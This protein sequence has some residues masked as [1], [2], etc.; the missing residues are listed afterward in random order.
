MLA[1]TSIVNHD[2]RVPISGALDVSNFVNSGASVNEIKIG[3]MLYF[4]HVDK[5]LPLRNGTDLSFA[6][7]QPAVPD[8]IERDYTLTTPA[9]IFKPQYQCMP[10]NTTERFG[11]LNEEGSF[12]LNLDVVPCPGAHREDPRNLTLS[13]TNLTIWTIPRSTRGPESSG[14]LHFDY[15]QF[16]CP[17]FLGNGSSPLVS[18]GERI[19]R[20]TDPSIESTA[21]YIVS[22][23]S[24]KSNN[25]RN[26]TTTIEC[27]LTASLS[28]VTAV[29][30]TASFAASQIEL[31]LRKAQKDSVRPFLLDT[32]HELSAKELPAQGFNNS[33]LQSIVPLLSEA[34]ADL[35]ESGYGTTQF[36]LYEPT[37]RVA[38]DLS[39]L[40]ARS[41]L[42]TGRDWHNLFEFF[43]KSVKAGDYQAAVN[44]AKLR[45]GAEATMNGILAQWAAQE[46]FSSEATTTLARGSY[47]Q[48][49]LHIKVLSLWI[50]IAC[51]IL[52][53]VLSLVLGF[54]L[55]S[56]D[57]VRSP[58]SI[59]GFTILLAED[60]HLQT[61]LET[62]MP[63][64]KVS[65][66][67]DPSKWYRPFSAQKQVIFFTL[68]MPVTL[69]VVLEVLQHL[70][71]S[72]HGI[73]Q[74]D[75]SKPPLY[76]EGWTHYLP[77]VIMISVAIA[78]ECL[79]FNVCMFSI[80]AKL[81]HESRSTDT[82][83]RD[84]SIPI[85]FRSLVTA[86]LTKQVGAALSILAGLLASVLTIA[87]SGLYSIDTMPVK[88]KMPYKIETYIDVTAINAANVIGNEPA[89]T[90]SLVD[91]F[92]L[93]F[94]SWT[95]D[96]LVLPAMVAAQQLMTD[97]DRV[98]AVFMPKQDAA[99]MTDA[100]LDI[101]TPVYHP[102]LDCTTLPAQNIVAKLNRSP[103]RDGVLEVN[104]TAVPVLSEDCLIQDSRNGSLSVARFSW[105]NVQASDIDGGGQMVA[106]YLSELQ[107]SNINDTISELWT[108][109]YHACPSLAFMVA[110]FDM[111]AVE[112]A[113]D[114][115]GLDATLAT[116][117]ITV[118]QCTQKIENVLADVQVHLPDFVIDKFQPPVILDQSVDQEDYSGFGIHLQEAFK[119][120]YHVPTTPTNATMSFDNFMQGVLYGSDPHD[121][122]D[123]I[124][125]DQYAVDSFRNATN[126]MYA[127]YTAQFLN[128]YCRVS[129]VSV[130]YSDAS[131]HKIHGN[132]TTWNTYRLVQHR[133]PKIALQI[134]LGTMVLCAALAYRLVDM[135]RTL[136]RE[137]CSIAGKASLVMGSRM[138]KLLEED[139]RGR[140]AGMGERM[141]DC[142]LS[143]GYML[144]L[145]WWEDKEE[146]DRI[147]TAVHGEDD[148]LD[149]RWGIDL[150][151]EL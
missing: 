97:E 146:R 37:Y 114:V 73:T 51:F 105:K 7:Q 89:M 14:Y 42:G 25:C 46:L 63:Q 75:K 131:F 150:V 147:G 1:P 49:K 3:S 48:D 41:D 100:L 87:V 113:S 40:K 55:P 79:D 136:L 76:L 106:S 128:A 90:L 13:S 12:D 118:L 143:E 71:D 138:L 15:Y 8:V 132:V 91:Q 2:I 82:V 116:D 35:P 124:G 115:D 111:D 80:F 39:S 145:G 126:R 23:I 81:K 77:T 67:T 11:T 151:E 101:Q 83:N 121:I 10:V 103:S 9:D 65:V 45:D 32:S 30:C 104:I 72:A 64:Q 31:G 135:R 92:N 60:K 6:F 69:F 130:G 137:P 66:T 61:M 36:D 57:L 96:E 142:G 29:A 98:M 119:T 140:G 120:S 22:E 122:R 54:S 70:S 125:S 127:R 93:S 33:L 59:T 34:A 149:A 78:Y 53:A 44:D 139:L 109:N 133:G 85:K 108:T 21:F 95:N 123:F 5:G 38:S 129:D 16:P 47:T 112:A 56:P 4:G 148:G 68:I 43:M 17:E 52:M 110:S 20:G 117:R 50:M 102:Y 18:M 58:A 107:Y 27:D 141:Q 84:L 74:I 24:F 88:F 86:C 28:N 99:N 94:P 19:V 62:S 26:S 144:K 134:L